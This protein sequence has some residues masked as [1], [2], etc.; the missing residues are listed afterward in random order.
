METSVSE[1]ARR[2]LKSNRPISAADV[3]TEEL[4]AK[5]IE[6]F[7]RMMDLGPLGLVTSE[8][9]KGGNAF[10]RTY[11][12]TDVGRKWVHKCMK[13][14]ANQCQIPTITVSDSV[15]RGANRR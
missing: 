14:E 13:R 1:I 15:K 6:I 10:H 2:I 11:S 3:P 7:A 12:I 5:K 4:G 8:L 9:V